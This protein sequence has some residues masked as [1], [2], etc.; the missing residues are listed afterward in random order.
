MSVCTKHT[1]SLCFQALL[2]VGDFF[3]KA[4]ILRSCNCTLLAFDVLRLRRGFAARWPIPAQDGAPILIA[5]TLCVIA[6]ARKSFGEADARGLL[7]L[8][9]LPLLLSCVYNDAM[10]VA[11]ALIGKQCAT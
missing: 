10:F 8:L 11:H 2:K 4:R 3:F 6:D 7:L 5:A 1:G 9:D